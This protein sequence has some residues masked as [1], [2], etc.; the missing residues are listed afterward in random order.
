MINAALPMLQADSGPSMPSVVSN[1]Q[2]FFDALLSAASNRTPLPPVPTGTPPP[3]GAA[4]ASRNG[5]DSAGG[6]Q[7]AL[8][9]APPQGSATGQ[10]QGQGNVIGGPGTPPVAGY[11]P[12]LQGNDPM[13][14]QVNDL[15]ARSK[16]A[17]A[18]GDTAWNQVQQQ[19]QQLGNVAVPQMPRPGVNPLQALAIAV[20]SGLFNNRF[21]NGGNQF[22]QAALGG[23]EQQK[24]TQ[25]QNEELKRQ[26][27]VNALQSSIEAAK[28]QSNKLYGLGGSL[29][30][31]GSNILA[32]QGRDLASN[33]RADQNL[34]G[35]LSTA[36]IQGAQRTQA[37][38]EKNLTA[39]DIAFMKVIND[40]NASP[41]DKQLALAAAKIEHPEMWD[42]A[43][44]GVDE[45]T[46]A[47]WAAS[48]PAKQLLLEAQRGYK[49]DQDKE[50]MRDADAHLKDL[51]SRYNLND[52]RASELQTIQDSIRQ[53]TPAEVAKAYE[54]I[55]G[56]KSAI[57]H[58]DYADAILAG[59]Q[60]I[61][62]TDVSNKFVN[63]AI[64]TYQKQIDTLQTTVRDLTKSRANALSNKDKANI[65]GQL[66]KTNQQIDR[67]TGAKNKLQ[68]E[69]QQAI[70]D[71][72]G[73]LAQ[74]QAGKQPGAAQPAATQKIGPLVYSGPFQ[75]SQPVKTPNGTYTVHDLMEAARRRLGTNPTPEA[76]QLAIKRLKD[77]GVDAS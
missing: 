64:G 52:A 39:K 72:H 28:D 75:P 5:T 67:L 26:A 68:T 13:I 19:Q 45:E 29:S 38:A 47:A 46:A 73:F 49:T 4:V 25:F 66:D 51:Q 36:Q 55:D 53:K 24:Q 41:V 35:K 42:P 14:Q 15:Y 22:G 74:H 33:Y 71:L 30:Q 60:H 3:V 43:K 6:I 18:Q 62:M 9:P 76:R 7:S 21:N 31:Q 32:W 63:D 2:A 27:A 56:I 8:S 69:G 20:G 40:P 17:I 48:T 61:K 77:L 59:D 1:P 58:R 44:G 11:S 12:S 10:A 34:L 50:F 54:E 65:D 57:G 37:A 23:I 70:S 16:A